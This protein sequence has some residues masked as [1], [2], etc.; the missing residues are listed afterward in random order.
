MS[1]MY[2]WESEIDELYTSRTILKTGTPLL[3]V[4][5]CL[6]YLLC[7]CSIAFELLRR[8]FF[9]RCRFFKICCKH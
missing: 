4:F 1:C 5:N 8:E 2:V 3:F 6:V 7:N 9:D